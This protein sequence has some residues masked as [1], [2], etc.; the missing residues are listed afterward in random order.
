MGSDSRDTETGK[1][2]IP[3]GLTG[4]QPSWKPLIWFGGGLLLL[5]GLWEVFLDVGLDLLEILFEILEKIWLVLIEAP[6]EWLE[7]QLAD[8]MKQHFQHDAHRY[9]EITTALGLTP[10]KIVL[11]FFLLRWGWRHC[12]THV[13]PQVI[14][15]SKIRVTQ[16]RLAWVEL[17]WPY[18]ILGCVAL[19]G[20]MVVLI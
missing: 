20:I 2:Q 5:I 8:W 13:I 1:A 18:R 17:W 11:M 12:R 14:L 4:I 10:L 9:S 16:V 19:I 7:D 15:W 6:E 3:E